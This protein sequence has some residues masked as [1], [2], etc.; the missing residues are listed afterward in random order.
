MNRYNESVNDHLKCI[1]LR[2]NDIFVYM[3]IERLYKEFREYDKA[4]ADY[5]KVIEYEPNKSIGYNLRALVYK[6]T[7]QYKKAIIDFSKAIELG[8]ND[9]DYKFR[10][11]HRGKCYEALGYKKHAETDLEKYNSFSKSK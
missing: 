3:D 8:S 1:E 6:V 9:W 10:Y 2:P 5:T 11:Y 4:I 7:K